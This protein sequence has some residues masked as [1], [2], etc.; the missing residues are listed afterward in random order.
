LHVCRQP[1]LPYRGYSLSIIVKALGKNDSFK[2][3]N[4]QGRHASISVY[5][6]ADFLESSL[7]LRIS[8]DL[9]TIS[10]LCPRDTVRT[11]VVPESQWNHNP[12]DSRFVRESC[13]LRQYW[14]SRVVQTSHNPGTFWDVVSRV[15]PTSSNYW[16]WTVKPKTSKHCV[17]ATARGQ[18]AIG[19]RMKTSLGDTWIRPLSPDSLARLNETSSQEPPRRGGGGETDFDHTYVRA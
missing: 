11:R 10:P 15:V 13:S 8:L 12:S 18:T 16:I 17:A 5:T 1:L 4:R 2:N 6:H 3:S 14:I 7:L 19:L 9:K